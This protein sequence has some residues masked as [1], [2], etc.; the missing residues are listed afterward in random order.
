MIRPSHLLQVGVD[1]NTIR[2][3]LG[4]TSVE[5]TNIY[6][7]VHMDIKAK[8][9]KECEIEISSGFDLEP[10]WRNDSNLMLFLKNL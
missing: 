9:L 4:H 1:I 7:E 2:H 5:T 3:W 6:E 10:E 8:G